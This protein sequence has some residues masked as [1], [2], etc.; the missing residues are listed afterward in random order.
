MQK[1]LIRA[2]F[3]TETAGSCTEGLSVFE[4]AIK[5]DAP[6]A[7]ALLDLNMPGFDGT[8]KVNAG[9]DLLSRLTSLQADLQIMVLT[10]YDEVALA[11]EAVNR[12]AKGYYVKGR[13]KGLVEKINNILEMK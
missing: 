3:E 11:K 9:L 1:T 7:I 13:E 8:P 12:G 5:N 4:A 10:A 6:F 2:G